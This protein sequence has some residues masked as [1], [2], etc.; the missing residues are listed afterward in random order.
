MTDW[1]IHL[2]DRWSFGWEDGKPTMSAEAEDLFGWGGIFN[3]DGLGYWGGES[4]YDEE[5]AERTWAS[6]IRGFAAEADI[7][8]TVEGP[9]PEEEES[10][11]P[12]ILPHLIWD[13]GP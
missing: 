9:A 8:I 2:S 1:V 7:S 6:I 10:S 13:G 5:W 12:L 11:P 3:V 4:E